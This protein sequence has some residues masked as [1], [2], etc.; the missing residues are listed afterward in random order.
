M[1]GLLVQVPGAGGGQVD[2]RCSSCNNF[3]RGEHRMCSNCEKWRDLDWNCTSCGYKNFAKRD[4]CKSCGAGH[5]PELKENREGGSYYGDREGD[6]LGGKGMIGYS[7]PYIP[8]DSPYL[9]AP[10]YSD[11]PEAENTTQEMPWLCG[12]CKSENAQQR[13]LCFECSGHR[14]RVEIRNRAAESRV[15]QQQ[16][17]RALSNPRQ[18][19]P[20]RDL[21]RVQ[22]RP[23]GP[24]EDQTL[25]W[26]CGH[27][28]NRN[29]ARRVKC[30]KCS[31]SRSEVEVKR[32]RE[33]SW[34]FRP[35]PMENF[36]PRGR[37]MM[38]YNEPL[39]D[40]RPE[41]RSQDWK[42]SSCENRNF[43]K[44][45]E[46][47]KCKKPRDE[48]EDKSI[49][50]ENEELAPI[51]K[52][53]A[54]PMV[55]MGPPKQQ[56]FDGREEDLSNDWVCGKCNI[57]CFAKKTH[58]FRCQKPRSE[59]ENRN[60]SALQFEKPMVGYPSNPLPRITNHKLQSNYFHDMPGPRAQ[61]EK[62][63]RKWVEEDKSNDW[64]CKICEINNFAKRKSCFR[65]NK[66]RE[67]CENLQ[68]SQQNLNESMENGDGE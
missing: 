67:E 15:V 52:R 5:I 17:G 42:C 29:F 56:R 12:M 3:N 61:Q 14:E 34:D 64:Y 7:D 18:M 37:P 50:Y 40:V 20:P 49:K 55:M 60:T 9:Q 58:C 48:V 6:M 45:K 30:N 47:N 46:C 32:P 24:T 10:S 21:S 62:T 26:D 33:S 8:S 36:A 1:S 13:I 43:A 51:R 27:C 39:P 41:D 28:Q 38:P 2:W 16:G 4:T 23:G 68:E 65:C 44:R 59:V 11:P 66:K 63:Q 22:Y 54:E 53:P 35:G 57:N 31:K 25:D 19:S